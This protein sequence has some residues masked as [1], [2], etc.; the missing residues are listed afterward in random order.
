MKSITFFCLLLTISASAQE[1]FQHNEPA[2]GIPC[3]VLGVRVFVDS[4]DENGMQRKPWRS[5]T[6]VW[7]DSK[8]FIVCNRC[9]SFKSPFQ[10]FTYKPDYSYAYDIELQ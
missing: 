6:D 7:I 4:Y 3:N 1:L 2:N 8:T 9:S 5:S 10:I